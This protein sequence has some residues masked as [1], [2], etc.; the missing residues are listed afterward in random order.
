MLEYSQK[1]FRNFIFLWSGEFI[2]AIGSGLTSFG[3][4][5]YVFH[6]TGSASDMALVTLLAFMPALLLSP[7]AGV[8]ADRYDR[9]LLMILG[10]GL[11][12][13][14]LLFILFCMIN[15]QGT[16]WQ[17]C[18]GV[19]ISS[20]F[21]SLMEPAYKATVTDLLSPAQY[22]KAS[23]LVGIAGSAKYLF[24]PMIAGLLLA[25]SDIK[26]LL[27]LDIV[28]FFIT[29][30]V[31]LVVRSGLKSPQRLK[32]T[33]GIAV[34]KSESPASFF[35]ELKAGFDAV[36]QNRGVLML[37]IMGAVI[38]LFLG[39]IQTLSAPMV[40]AFAGSATLGVAET[41]CATGMLVSSIL[42]GIL[43]IKKGYA[44]ILSAALF[45]AGVFMAMFGFSE[46]IMWICISGFLF[47]AMLP[48]ANSSLDYMLRSNI[49]NKLQGRAW[50]FI[51]V[52]SQLGYV[53]A[54]AFSGMLADS[55]GQVFGIGVGRGAGLCIVI[56]GVLLSGTSVFLYTLKSVKRLENGGGICTTES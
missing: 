44:K 34:E 41:I 20:V 10:D 36:S 55:A 42:I 25:V 4:S 37:V 53:V 31:T 5:V 49:A 2:S 43:S 26:L 33:L 40:L 23:G 13:T 21:S 47:F 24:S 3:L 35:L 19:T 38:T 29:V 7:I 56:A 54:Y 16:L 48:F 27:I 32:N 30:T 45:F 12:A 6:L 46:N 15:G 50:G 22:T 52:I 1:S 9:R 11:S 28:T 39:F 51:G 17:I 14:G 8:L 18:I